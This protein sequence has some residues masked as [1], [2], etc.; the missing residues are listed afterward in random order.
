MHPAIERTYTSW[1][2][3][4]Q[5]NERIREQSN[6]IIELNKRIEEQSKF[7]TLLHAIKS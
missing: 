7:I 2:Q 5:L 4:R 6:M 3:T 1:Q